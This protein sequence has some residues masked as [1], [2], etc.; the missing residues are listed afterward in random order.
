MG[1]N[2]LTHSRETVTGFDTP[3]VG[4]VADE[5]SV[6]LHRTEVRCKNPA[7]LLNQRTASEL[8]MYQIISEPFIFCTCKNARMLKNW[9]Q[10]HK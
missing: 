9:I 8:T 7:G 6:H 2:K 1:K 10:V 3:G 5:G 4:W